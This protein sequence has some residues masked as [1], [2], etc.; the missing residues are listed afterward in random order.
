MKRSSSD[1]NAA[2]ERV[3]NSVAEDN[4]ATERVYNPPLAFDAATERVINDQLMQSSQLR[5]QVEFNNGMWWEM[6]LQLSS[7]LLEK[8]R[9]DFEEAAFV[10]DWGDTR[11]GSFA[12]DGEKTSVNRY[13]L[14][15]RTMRQ[16]NMD[17]ERTRRARIV[18]IVA[19]M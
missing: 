17:N 7:E 4:T 13:V 6:P 1:V 11:E 8:K 15:F 3:F 19:G 5:I 9:Q 14:N 16:H 12:P 10:W 2:E 18:H